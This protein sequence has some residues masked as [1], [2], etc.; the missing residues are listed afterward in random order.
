MFALS[1]L[2]ASLALAAQPA[3]LT[4]EGCD[5]S[6]PEC[7]C[8]CGKAHA[9]RL[10]AQAGL[11]IGEEGGPGYSPREALTD[12]DLLQ[13][14]LEMEIDPDNETISGVNVMQ[15]RSTVNGLT[16]FTIDRVK[17]A[18][19]DGDALAAM[20]DEEFAAGWLAWMKE[21]A[22]EAYTHAKGDGSPTAAARLA[23]LASAVKP[24]A[25]T[26]AD[27]MKPSLFAFVADDGYAFDR[28]QS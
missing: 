22:P 28:S 25:K 6:N 21:Y 23:L 9:L 27:A 7:A 14:D 12:T 3:P 19:F 5:D 17:L 2:T 16:Q 24:R 10:R 15:V 13:C 1:L 8:P 26:Y 4:P 11:P 20:T 18:S